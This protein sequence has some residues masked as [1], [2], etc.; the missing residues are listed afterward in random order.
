VAKKCLAEWLP[1]YRD[2]WTEDRLTFGVRS[3]RKGLLTLG[4]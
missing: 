1:S 4:G 3:T 2:A